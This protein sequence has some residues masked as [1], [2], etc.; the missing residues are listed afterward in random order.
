[1]TV[2]KLCCCC[3][4]GGGASNKVGV[5]DKK[6][7]VL[8]MLGL[9]NAGKTCTAK[10]LVGEPSSAVENTAPTVGFS[11]V[12]TKYKGY[13][14]KIYDLG[15]SKGFR[16]IWPS[17]FHE[18]HGF[19]FVVDSA[20]LTRMSE[21][22]DVFQEILVHDK[23]KGKPVLLLCNKSDLEDA[24][25]EVEVVDALNVEAVVN[26]ARCPTRVEPVVAVK[27]HGLRVGFKWIVKSIIAN[28]S[29][30]GS[31]VEADVEAERV[32]EAKRKAEARARIAEIRRK[33]EEEE[34]NKVEEDPGDGGKGFVPLSELKNSWVD[35]KKDNS[36]LKIEKNKPKLPPIEKQKV[37]DRLPKLEEAVEP[38][39]DVTVFNS[40][41][42]DPSPSLNGDVGKESGPESSRSARSENEDA[43]IV[44]VEP[45]VE[46][47][48]NGG[49]P[50]VPARRTLTAS[51][52]TEHFSGDFAQATSLP[53]SSSTATNGHISTGARL[54]LEP[55]SQPKK[56]TRFLKG[57]AGKPGMRNRGSSVDSSN[58][59]SK[60]NS[61][62]NSSVES[63]R[64][65]QVIRAYT[66]AGIGVE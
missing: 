20:D 13:K 49:F 27:N 60:P 28:Y 46:V 26:A 25:D 37:A 64:D 14:V 3:A 31:R 58:A 17:Y 19:I 23:V 5:V 21:V 61:A 30:L 11:S 22:R 18:V 9:D 16:G 66:G 24:H 35:G 32:L 7:I 50:P 63:V 48:S 56:R 8:L 55:I 62:T 43:V 41:E 42:N 12:E 52:S 4:G 33:R 44:E 39:G 29:E 15:G 45:S 47:Q 1:M 38:E 51:A 6:A 34:E 2:F 57:K 10:S 54:E 36:D 53:P 40:I 65:A 59:S